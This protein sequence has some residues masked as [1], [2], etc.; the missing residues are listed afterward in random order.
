MPRRIFY[1]VACLLLSACAT[2]PEVKNLPPQQTEIRL[3]KVEQ[4][5]RQNQVKQTG[6]L[7][8]QFAPRQW[9]WVQTDSLG[10][11]TARLLLTDKGWENDGFIMPNKQAQQ[12][13]SAL[14]TVL[15]S[16]EPIFEFSS[17]SETKNGRIYQINHKTVWT[18]QQKPPQYHISLPDES[19]W[20]I[21]ELNQ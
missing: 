14:A 12:V 18:I 20:Q 19:E 10:A 15:N 5:E 3:F 1:I 16:A 9:R 7:T 17:V 21:E 11:P 8:V 13:F 6:L 2:Q 4:L